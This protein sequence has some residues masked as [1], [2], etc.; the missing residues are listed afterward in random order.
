MGVY[1]DDHV[2]VID[3]G[4]QKILVGEPE[5]AGIVVH[6][7][8]LIVRAE[9]LGVLKGGCHAALA[10]GRARVAAA[11]RKGVNDVRNIAGGGGGEEGGVG[12]GLFGEGGREEPEVGLV[13]AIRCVVAAVAADL[14]QSLCS[15]QR[16]EEQEEDGEGS[17]VHVHVARR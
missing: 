16:R 8:F 6:G 1:K 9:L 12:R 13:G 3:G 14:P 5:H 11:E 7:G 15:G 10:D 2:S 4:S 17:H